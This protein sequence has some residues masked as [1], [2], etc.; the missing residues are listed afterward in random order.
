MPRDVQISGTTL[1]WQP[2]LFA[3]TAADAVSQYRISYTA[4]GQAKPAVFATLA[5]TGTSID[6]ALGCPQYA[7]CPLKGGPVEPGA[8]YRWTVAA[9]GSSGAASAN[10]RSTTAVWQ[11]PAIAA[12][13]TPAVAP[14]SMPVI[15]GLFETSL[16]WQPPAYFG[17]LGSNL[18]Q[19]SIR[20]RP[21]G[22]RAFAEYAAIPAD[23]TVFDLAGPCPSGAVCP[24][25]TGDLVPGVVYEVWVYAVGADGA[26]SKIPRGAQ[27]YSFLWG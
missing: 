19:Y 16:S 27:P 25:K 11:G 24:K 4:E 23:Q 3:G 12:P 2:P 17:E 9:V 13:I 6:L 8:T 22:E 21:L 14:P 15:N 1:S 5:G 10:A 26:L 18:A 20:I 7:V